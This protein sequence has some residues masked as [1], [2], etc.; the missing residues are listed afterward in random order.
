MIDTTLTTKHF[1]QHTGIGHIFVVEVT[2]N[3]VVVGSY[4]PVSADD[5]KPPYNYD[6]T[7][8]INAWLEIQKDMLVMIGNFPR[9][10]PK[11][12]RLLRRSA[13]PKPSKYIVNHSFTS[14]Y[15]VKGFTEFVSYSSA[16]AGGA[17]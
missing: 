12:Q 4:G 3:R 6:C 17:A 11:P 14:A 16:T 10:L 5:L 2:W 9:C 13:M 8:K 15:V 7:T 1:F